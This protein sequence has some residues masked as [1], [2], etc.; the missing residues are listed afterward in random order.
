MVLEVKTKD[1]S[2][3]LAALKNL[4]GVTSLSLL[5]HDGELRE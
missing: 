5:E 1:D 4:D 3:M 2:G